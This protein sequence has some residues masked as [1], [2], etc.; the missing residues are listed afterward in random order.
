MSIK[1]RAHI[2]R[3]MM[4]NRTNSSQFLAKFS[5]S[6]LSIN[7]IPIIYTVQTFETYLP[8]DYEMRLLCVHES[9]Q[10]AILAEALGHEG[11]EEH[12]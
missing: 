6:V 5:V 4:M 7:V 9:N 8:I 3:V 12:S 2:Q 11:A 1:P 10:S